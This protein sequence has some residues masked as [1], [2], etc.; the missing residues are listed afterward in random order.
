MGFEQSFYPESRFGGFTDVD[1]TVAFYTRV[2]SMVGPSDVVLDLGCG[3]GAYQD[4][5]VRLRREL[6][7]FKGK[8]RRVIGLDSD[9]AAEANPYLDEFHLLSSDDWPLP[10]SSVDLCVCDDV[11][12][13]VERPDAFFREAQRV[14]R[15]GGTLCIRTPNAWNYIS[16]VARL[17]PNRL[18]ASV[19]ARVQDGR[20]EEDVFPTLFR[21]NTIGKLRQSLAEN[22][23]E[24]VVYGY[25]AEPSYLSFSKIAYFFGVLWQRLAPPF[26]R[27]ALFAFGRLSKPA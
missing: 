3:R 13:H 21:C 19:L 1:G 2:Q 16:L 23:F 11:L 22:G 25:D 24:H 7:I 9:P 12:E 14:L 4:D 10:D 18:H 26:L 17:V 20:K 6:R 8:A 15:D 5:P 27:S